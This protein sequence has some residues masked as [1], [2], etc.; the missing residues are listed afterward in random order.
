[1]IQRFS[2]ADI[3]RRAAADIPAGSYVNLGIGM[4]VMALDYWTPE[5]GVIVHSENGIL[6]MRARSGD[7]PV[8]PDLT[9]AAKQNVAMASG[10]SFFNHADS[11]AIMR[12]GHLDYCI[13]GAYQVSE[14]GDLA[15]WSLGQPGVAAA[16][17]GAMD[18]AV[19]A[20]RV[21]V[22]MEHTTRDGSSRLRRVCDLPLTGAACVDRVYTDLATLDVTPDGFMVRSMAPGLSR[23]ALQAVT[24]APLR[25][26]QDV[27][28]A[29]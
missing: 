3:A 19:G 9:N 22:L 16:V 15:N 27:N 6:G 25:F 26:A 7:D 4:P 11:F 10:G 24:D 8:D 20:K 17:G 21:H 2:R 18:L 23:E 5:N 14:N 28:D 1:M 29:G 13:L 12:G